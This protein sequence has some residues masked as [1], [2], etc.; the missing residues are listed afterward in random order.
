MASD[1]EIE[2]LHSIYKYLNFN[3]SVANWKWKSNRNSAVC[4]HV[5]D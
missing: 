3:I 5:K 4:E 2:V 1:T